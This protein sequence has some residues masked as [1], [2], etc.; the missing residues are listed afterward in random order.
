MTKTVT[1]TY[2]LPT[3]RTDGTPLASSEIKFV[4]V[5]LS[6]N[7]GADFSVVDV[8]PP[9]STTFVQTD[10]EAG[11]WPFRFI[12]EMHDGARSAGKDFNAVIMGAAPNDVTNIQVVIS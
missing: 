5:S 4:E 6:I 10:L 12:V 2:D 3:E 7:G 9:D 1:L 8:V 11:T